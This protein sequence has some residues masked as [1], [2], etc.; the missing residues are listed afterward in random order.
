MMRMPSETDPLLPR[1]N[2]AP[3]ISGH[4]FSKPSQSRYQYQYQYQYQNQNQN[5]YQTQDEVLDHPKYIENKSEQKARTSYGDISPLRTIFVIFVLVVGFAIVFSLLMPGA[6][7]IPWH[8]SKAP[9]D[10]TL[11]VKARVDKIL[12]ETPL[13]GPPA[14]LF[15]RHVGTSSNSRVRWA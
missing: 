5:Q 13:I 7:D 14:L 6:F 4:G 3:E 9:K 2:T 10:E 15:R 1:G 11:T 8:S 12:A